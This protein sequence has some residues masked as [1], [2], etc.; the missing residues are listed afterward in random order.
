M[1]PAND[2]L[3]DDTIDDL[4]IVYHDEL[5][6][7]NIVGPLEERR[8]NLPPREFWNAVRTEEGAEGLRPEPKIIH[9][10]TRSDAVCCVQWHGLKAA[11]TAFLGVLATSASE[12]ADNSHG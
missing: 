6:R 3:D 5:N 2:V 4:L 12:E 7:W 8:T 11:L 9:F 10:K 1:T